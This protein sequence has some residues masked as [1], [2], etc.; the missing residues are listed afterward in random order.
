M[1][2]EFLHSFNRTLLN[3]WKNSITISGNTSVGN[4]TVHEQGN[5][6]AE[7]LSS[8]YESIQHIDKIG[9]VFFHPRT[10]LSQNGIITTAV[11]RRP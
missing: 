7:V 11:Q 8:K 5:S 2:I 1:V 10:N 6:W 9:Y 3:E 4:S